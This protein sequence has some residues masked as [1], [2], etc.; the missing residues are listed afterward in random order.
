[1]SWKT[2]SYASYLMKKAAT[3]KRGRFY[4]YLLT[5]AICLAAVLC[6]QLLGSCKGSESHHQQGRPLPLLHFQKTSCFGPC[7][8]YEA[9]ILTDG[10]VTFA[11]SAHVPSTDTLAFK[12]SLEQ[13]DSLET[14]LANLEYNAL[15]DFYPTDWSDMPSTITNF[16]KDGK[17]VKRVKHQEGGPNELIFFQ[18]WL[19]K[20]LLSLAEAEARRSLPIK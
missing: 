19:N 17:E 3:T 12:L 16:Y 14:H 13:L 8:V 9:T 11:G 5:G 6:S 4:S 10:S 15:K 7:P 18:K 20:A 1:M 2:G